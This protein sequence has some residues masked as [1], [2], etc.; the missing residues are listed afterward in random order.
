M[1]TSLQYFNKNEI[2]NIKLDKQFEGRELQKSRSGKSEKMSR[3]KS[4]S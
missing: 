1:A 4:R 2:N 3:N